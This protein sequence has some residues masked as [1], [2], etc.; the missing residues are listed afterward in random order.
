MVAIGKVRK[1]IHIVP[2]VVYDTILT[3]THST[4]KVMRLE[5]DRWYRLRVAVVIPSAMPSDL[6]FV[7]GSCTVHRV[8]SDGVWHTAEFVAYSDSSFEL[9]GASRADFA[10]R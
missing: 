2:A 5:S 8:A 3:H 10:V 7:G 1:N 9:T 4:P 6:T